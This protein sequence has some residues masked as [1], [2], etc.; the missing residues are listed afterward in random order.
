MEITKYPYKMKIKVVADEIVNSP[1]TESG[2]AGGGPS[3]VRDAGG[4]HR[5]TI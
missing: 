3:L 1:V 2:S 4:P 5:A